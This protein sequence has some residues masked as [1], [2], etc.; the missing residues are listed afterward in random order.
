MRWPS[1]PALFRNTVQELAERYLLHETIQQYKLACE[2]QKFFDQLDVEPLSK[3]TFDSLKGQRDEL[4]A[5]YGE[6]FKY[7]YG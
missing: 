6:T 4:V 1:S 5:R 3:E 7:D 2:Y